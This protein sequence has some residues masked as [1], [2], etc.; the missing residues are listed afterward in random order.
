MPSYLG[1]TNHEKNLPSKNIDILY[2]VLSKPIANEK[3]TI[4]IHDH[5]SSIV[6]SR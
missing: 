3:S 5:G 1:K 2:V 4:R 6:V